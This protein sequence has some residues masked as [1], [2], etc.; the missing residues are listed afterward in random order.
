MGGIDWM[1]YSLQTEI[2]FFCVLIA[3]DILTEL[4][5]V[6]QTIEDG[7]TTYT[8]VPTSSKANIATAP[9]YMA[10]QKLSLTKQ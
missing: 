5:L 6:T 4:G 3:C 10:L 8:V 9:T 2:N 1:A 7:A